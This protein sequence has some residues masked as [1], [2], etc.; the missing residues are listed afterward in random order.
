MEVGAVAE[1]EQNL[2]VYEEWGE[3]DGCTNAIRR[4]VIGVVIYDSER[5]S[6]KIVQKRRRTMFSQAVAKEL[7]NPRERLDTPGDGQSILLVRKGCGG[8]EGQ[9]HLRCVEELMGN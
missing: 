3:D 9:H 8:Q 7:G 1:L 6:E 4:I 5:T 2:Q